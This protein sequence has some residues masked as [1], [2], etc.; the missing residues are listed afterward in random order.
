MHPPDAGEEI[1]R[2]AVTTVRR[3]C[4]TDVS[5]VHAI[6]KESPEA[7]MWSRESLLE[8]IALGF[9]WVAEREAG[10]AG[11][12]IGFVV[13]RLVADELEILNLAVGKAFRR[14]GIATQLVGVAL[15]DARAARVRQTFL[16]VRAS[17]GG[18]IALYA[19]LGFRVC[20]RRAKYYREPVE[21]ALLLVL[22]KDETGS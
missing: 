5:R 7:S 19:R 17:N 13:G 3:M 22:H 18:A 9:A 10:I 15:S 14:Q 1:K 6:L 4:A 8:T 21:D 11:S 12:A 2:T 16:E 20:G